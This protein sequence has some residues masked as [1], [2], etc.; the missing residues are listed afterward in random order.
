MFAEE[1]LRQVREG[2]KEWEKEV[3]KV[4]MQNPERKGGF[5]TVSDMGIKIIYTPE[6]IKDLD[7]ARYWLSWYFPVYQGMSA[8]NVSGEG[9][10]LPY[11]LRNGQC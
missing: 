9:V 10:D 11:V 6:D 3:E 8:N 1:T 5:S 4:I 7:F 2:K